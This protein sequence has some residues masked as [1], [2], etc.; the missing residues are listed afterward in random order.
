MEQKICQSCG[1]P[2][3]E[4]A[5]MAA[6]NQ[7]GT[8]NEEYCRYCYENGAFTSEQTMEEMIEFCIP[9]LLK[10]HSEMTPEQAREMMQGFFPLLKRWQQ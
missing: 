10:E 2:L 7:D 3:G 4:N 6:S 1:M 8:K 9:H 5:E